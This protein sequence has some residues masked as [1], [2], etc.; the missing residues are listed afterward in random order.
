MSDVTQETIV[1][2]VDDQEDIADVYKLY[3]EESYE[4]QVEYGGKDA[5]E[6]ID[7]SV[8][9]VLLDRRMPDLSG[10]VVLQKIREQGFEC[11]VIV[12]S[13]VDPDEQGM[14]PSDEYL[15]KPV[16]KE[17]LHEAIESQLGHA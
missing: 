7:E 6:T 11:R 3:L 4:V 5:L 14:I 12:I 13:A 2:I 16:F 15:E 17:E 10:D 8:D 9:V 1:L